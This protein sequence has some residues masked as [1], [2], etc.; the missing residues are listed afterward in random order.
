VTAQDIH[1]ICGI[2][3]F[4]ADN[5]VEIKRHTD[6]QLRLQDPRFGETGVGSETV[7]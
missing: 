1:T 2:I 3:K 4:A 6:M 5:K 7:L